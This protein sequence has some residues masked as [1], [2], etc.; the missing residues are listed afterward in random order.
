M[1]LPKARNPLESGF[2]LGTQCDGIGSKQHEIYMPNAAPRVGDPTP[3]IFHRL[4]LQVGLGGNA[5]F[6]VL[7]GKQILESL[8]TNMLE[9][10]TQNCGVGCLSQCKDP[11][12]IV[13]HRSGL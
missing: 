13:L 3:P 9:Y 6:S 1:A 4:A 10:P 2:P 8:D 5:N 12:Q 11:T 7:G